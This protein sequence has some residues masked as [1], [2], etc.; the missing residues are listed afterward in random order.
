MAWA[1]SPEKATSA[2]PKLTF[3]VPV[4]EFLVTDLAGRTWRL[5][6]LKGKVTLL[7]FWA[8]WCGSCRG[9]LPYIQK[10]YDRLK[11]RSDL[12]VLTINVDD[13]PALIEGYL[14]E[15]NFTFPILPA[16]DL[17]E[18]IFPVIM[19]PQTWIVDA[20]GRRSEEQWVGGSDDWVERT[21]TQMERVRG[22]IK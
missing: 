12:Q 8:T 5:S 13:N 17:A 6:D 11:G 18:K 7:D 22:D 9:E 19:L 3:S 1:S 21:I 16:K 14:K 20:Q 10:L 15:T 4:P 2:E